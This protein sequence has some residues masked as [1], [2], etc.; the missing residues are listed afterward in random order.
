MTTSPNQRRRFQ[1]S[2]RTMLLVVLLLSI[3]FSYVGSYYRL[4]RRGMREAAQYNSEWFLYV[5][6]EE[7]FATEDLTQHHLRAWF[8][9]PVNWID[10]HLFGGPWPVGDI[11]FRLSGVP[12]N[13]RGGVA[14]EFDIESSRTLRGARWQWKALAV[15]TVV[16]HNG[17]TTGRGFV[18]EG[19]P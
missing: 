13:A 18:R 2:L 17:A 8:F 14:A 19:L 1:F 4:S 6:A 16:R 3:L 7:V 11:S 12:G 15:Q 9:A 10:R 5:P